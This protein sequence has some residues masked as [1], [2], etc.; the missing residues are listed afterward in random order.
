MKPNLAFAL[1]LR[2][3]G[4]K[5]GNVWESGKERGKKI[6]VSKRHDAKVETLDVFVFSRKTEKSMKLEIQ[7]YKRIA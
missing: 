3:G 4:D 6:K 2:E 1:E 5:G 7:G